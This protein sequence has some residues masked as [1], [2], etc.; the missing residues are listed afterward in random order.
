MGSQQ[1]ESCQPY[2]ASGCVAAA[3][4]AGSAGSADSAG[5][6]LEDGGTIEILSGIDLGHMKHDE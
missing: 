1:N 3:V 5:L 2:F 4:G 6:S